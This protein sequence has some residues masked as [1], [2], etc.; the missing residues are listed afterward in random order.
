MKHEE[1]RDSTAWW[2]TC[3]DCITNVVVYRHPEAESDL[4]DMDEWENGEFFSRCYV[5]DGR[6]QWGGSDR[7]KDV[8]R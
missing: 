1:H 6:V 3:D 5:C 7:V 4:P 8:L 2:G